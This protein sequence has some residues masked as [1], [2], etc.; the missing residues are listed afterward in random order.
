MVITRQEFDE[1]HNHSITVEFRK[2]L[3]S[4]R[5]LLKEMLLAG[6]ENDEKVR[7]QAAAIAS[8]LRMTYEDLIESLR[9]KEYE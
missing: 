6:T 1:W 3:F 4:D 7:G 5:E 8:I 2:A 9:D